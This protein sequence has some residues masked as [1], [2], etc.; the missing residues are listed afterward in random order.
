MCSVGGVLK[1][2]LGD[3]ASKSPEYVTLT[4]LSPGITPGS[5]LP[6]FSDIGYSIISKYLWRAEDCLFH[7]LEDFV[8]FTSPILYR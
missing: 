2:H 1:K 8:G 7:L 3:S 6:Y 4:S 5:V